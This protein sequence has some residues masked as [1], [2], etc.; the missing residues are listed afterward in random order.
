M[1]KSIFSL[2]AILLFTSYLGYGQSDWQISITNGISIPTGNFEDFAN[3]GLNAELALEKELCNRF[4]LTGGFRYSSFENNIDVSNSN[5]WD[6]FSFLFGPKYEIGKQ[7]LFLQLYQRFG[8]TFLNAPFDELRL[9]NTDVLIA[10]VNN[11][12]S[13]NIA[14]LSG[15]QLNY[16]ICNGFTLFVNSEYFT[17]LQNKLRTRVRNV[18]NAVDSNGNISPDLLNTLPFDESRL[19]LSN[20][21]FNICIKFF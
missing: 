3:Q 19:N 12:K 8:M 6:T 10:S 21:N 7:R 4:G 20:I 18:N 17:T 14:S 5:S 1:N 15:V 16:E 11:R 9:D 13:T 2:L